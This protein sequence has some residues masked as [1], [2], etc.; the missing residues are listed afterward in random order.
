MKHTHAAA[1]YRRGISA[2][3]R[4]G[5]GDAGSRRHRREI[6]HWTE[7]I[8]QIEQDEIEGWCVDEARGTPSSRSPVR[9]VEDVAHRHLPRGRMRTRGEFYG[10]STCRRR[11]ELD[12]HRPTEVG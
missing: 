5:A 2:A 10:A 8:D 11:G 6:D 12:Q 3:A 9:Y 7:H 1:S 4:C